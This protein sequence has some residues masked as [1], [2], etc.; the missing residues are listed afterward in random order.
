MVESTANENLNQEPVVSQ[1]AVDVEMSEE[2][3]PDEVKP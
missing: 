3:K 1:P 2:P